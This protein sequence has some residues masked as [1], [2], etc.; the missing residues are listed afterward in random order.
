MARALKAHLEAFP[1]RLVTLPWEN[2]DST[3]LVA[4]P[5]VLTNQDGGATHRCTFERAH[6]QKALKRAGVERGSDRENGSHALRHFYASS[7]LHAGES[8]RAVSEYL[9]HANPAFTL[10]IYTHLMPGSQDRTRNAI[11]DIL[12]G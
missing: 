4:V 7:L 2:P 5:L 11:D 12:D 6:W 10:R 3:T 9:G 1:A 8:I